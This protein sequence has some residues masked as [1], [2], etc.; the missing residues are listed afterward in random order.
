VHI[1]PI[2]TGYED[3]SLSAAEDLAIS[4]QTINELV[5]LKR[6]DTPITNLELTLRNTLEFSEQGDLLNCRAGVRFLVVMANGILAPCS[7][8]RTKYATHEEMIKIFSK[9]NR[10][11]KCYVAIRSYSE[12]P[13]VAGPKI[14]LGASSK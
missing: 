5:I 6:R 8:Q 13:L 14:S 12:M 3:Y 2:R 1:Q 4:R 9:T 7:L 11:D 10:C